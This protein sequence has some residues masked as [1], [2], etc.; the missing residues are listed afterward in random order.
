MVR[1]S[2][3]F[4][5]VACLCLAA[6]PASAARAG[7]IITISEVGSDVVVSGSGILNLAG[8]GSPQAIGTKAEL[9]PSIAIALVGPPGIAGADLFDGITGP[10]SFGSGGPMFP[11]SGTGMTF[12][13]QAARNELLVPINYVSN[14]PLSG[15]STYS[16]QTL[17]GL[18]LTPGTHRWTW[19]SGANADFLEVD[20]PGAPVPEPSSLILAA[21]GIGV[22]GCCIAIRRR[23]TAAALA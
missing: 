8:L 22:V 21:M 15:T 20:I 9:D 5:L 2:A 17:A 19:G 10:S 7:V 14:D 23:R 3:V 13:V 6:W 4:V 11:D 18:G 16:G 12:G 1:D